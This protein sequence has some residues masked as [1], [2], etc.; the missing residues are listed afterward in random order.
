VL[1]RL[2]VELQRRCVSY[3]ELAARLEALESDHVRLES[4]LSRIAAER[5]GYRKNLEVA[6]VELEKMRRGLSSPHERER[7]S[8]DQ[9]R[10]ATATLASAIPALAP[11]AEP[12]TDDAPADN[13]PKKKLTPHVRRPIP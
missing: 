4:E 2:R 11:L 9:L 3:E 6:L 13:T 7:V 1:Q 10:L 8:P 5:D 12:P